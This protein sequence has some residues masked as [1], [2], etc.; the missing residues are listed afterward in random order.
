VYT[1]LNGIPT[2]LYEVTKVVVRNPT[3]DNA[4]ELRSSEKVK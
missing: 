1:K 3:L 2:N 4:G